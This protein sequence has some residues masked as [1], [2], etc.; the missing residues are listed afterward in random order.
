MSK[1]NVTTIMDMVDSFEST[2]KSNFIKDL[3]TNHVSKREVSDLA[4]AMVQ[5]QQEWEQRKSDWDSYHDA[6][7]DD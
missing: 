6:A 7:M 2:D 1:D 5:R 4:D 3:L